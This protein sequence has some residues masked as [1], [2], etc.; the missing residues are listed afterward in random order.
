MGVYFGISLQKTESNYGYSTAKLG[1]H[2]IFVLD[3]QFSECSEFWGWRSDLSIDY[4]PKKYW[5]IFIP[6]RSAA[7]GWH[8]NEYGSIKTD[9]SRLI[10]WSI[11]FPSD[12]PDI[13]LPKLTRSQ[14]D[15]IYLVLARCLQDGLAPSMITKPKD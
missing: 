5:P 14:T 1:E 11:G 4:M 12:I 9:D 3:G 2:D 8:V 15:C 6:T 7:R 13:P 10:D